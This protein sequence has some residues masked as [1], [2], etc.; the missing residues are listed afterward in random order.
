[1]EIGGNLEDALIKEIKE[2]SG[3]D[4]SVSSLIGVYSNA[5][6]HQCMTG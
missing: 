4:I 5:G 3:I 2:E 1:V 6:V